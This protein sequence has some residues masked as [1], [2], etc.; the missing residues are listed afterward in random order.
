[1]FI[2]DKNK[3]LIPDYF[4]F[5]KGLVD[6][7]DLSLNLSREMLQH[8]RQL[9]K[10]ASHLEKKIKSELESMLVDDRETYLEFYEAYKLTLKYGIYEM[11][12]MNKDKLQDLIL[13]ETSKSDAPIA[14]K[15]Y[16]DRK[17]ESQKFIYYA[18]GKSKSR[19]LNLPQMDAMKS[20]DIE[21]LLCYD[22]V[23]EFMFQAMQNYQDVTFKS[24]QKGDLEEV[25]EDK[26]KEVKKQE[27]DYKDF[28]KAI[29]NSLKDQVKDVKVSSRLTESP[30][31][32]VS[33]EGVSLEME[34]VLNQMPNGESV[35]AERILEVNPNH[36]LFKKLHE[37]F[38]SDDQT[39]DSIAS[40]LYYQS[41]VAEGIPLE[42]PKAYTDALT[43][44]LSK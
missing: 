23:D 6:S 44:L 22:D 8:D 35:K 5:V 14:L 9:K 24:I 34:K 19:M 40:L 33:G 42:N 7:A 16:I 12:G 10:I 43:T 29:K 18:T 37:T 39:I 41:L 20:Q 4:K 28:L 11:F 36:A 25:Q 31:C 30:V 32:I 2:E 15:E 26:K 17:P 13:F 3:S 38:V 21:V 1:V 27:K